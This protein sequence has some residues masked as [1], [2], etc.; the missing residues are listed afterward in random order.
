MYKNFCYDNFFIV[1]LLSFNVFV[2][3]NLCEQLKIFYYN[4]NRTLNFK[5]KVFVNIVSKYYS[6][7]TYNIL[8]TIS[9]LYK[10]D[11]LLLYEN[12][13]IALKK[14]FLSLNCNAYKT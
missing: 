14:L 10:K 13:L 3:K 2:Q 7:M 9:L 8:K 12:V 6:I 4:L 5:K 1:L 11:T